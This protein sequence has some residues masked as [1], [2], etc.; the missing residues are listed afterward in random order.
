LEDIVK[1]YITQVGAVALLLSVAILPAHA[2]SSHPELQGR[3]FEDTS[4]QVYA[5]ND[6]AR[7]PIELAQ[8]DDETFAALA[9]GQ[10]VTRLDELFKVAGTPAPVATTPS[11]PLLYQTD[12][13]QGASGWTGDRSWKPVGGMLVTAPVSF[14]RGVTYAPYRAPTADYAV[15]A[16]IQVLPSSEGE[17][18]GVVARSEGGIDRNYAGAS[19]RGRAIVGPVGMY[20]SA[21]DGNG[22]D[23]GTDWHTYR[24]EAKANRLTLSI[25]GIQL[26]SVMDNAFTKG[27]EVGLA[28]SAGANVRAFRVYGL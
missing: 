25:D 16:E 14:T 21:I 8:V 18:V 27:Q 11:G 23:A 2:E 20:N 12:F 17:Y 6:G 7:I 19:W 28:A 9:Q 22:F 26:V 24:L 1:K 5:V 15:E 4:G 10:S 3:L 13:S